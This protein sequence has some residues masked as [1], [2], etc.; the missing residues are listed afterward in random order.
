[1]QNSR[2]SQSP[3][4]NRVSLLSDPAALQ[5]RSA[6][7]KAFRRFFISQMHEPFGWSDC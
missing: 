2:A 7:R 5:Q 6:D 1:M 3:V 4:A